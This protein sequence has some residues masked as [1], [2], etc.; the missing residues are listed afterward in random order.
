MT[1]AVVLVY[2]IASLHTNNRRVTIG[3]TGR[4]ANSQITHIEMYNYMN[5]YQNLLLQQFVVER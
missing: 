4:K 3:Q 5:I 2:T 1:E